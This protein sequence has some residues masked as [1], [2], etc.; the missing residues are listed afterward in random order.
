MGYELCQIHSNDEFRYQ[1]SVWPRIL[2]VA[3]EHGWHAEGTKLRSDIPCHKEWDGTYFSN[4]GQI[5]SKQDA[6]NLAFA[7]AKALI[8]IPDEPTKE[9]PFCYFTSS[10]RQYLIEFIQFCKKGPFII[11]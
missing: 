7:L 11:I 6:L 1:Y 3:S 9:E 4:D 2:L 5:V 10:W 8:A